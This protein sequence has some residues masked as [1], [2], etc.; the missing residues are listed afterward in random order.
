MCE[1]KRWTKWEASNALK[2]QCGWRIGYSRRIT[3]AEAGEVDKAKLYVGRHSNF[4][5][6]P[7]RSQETHFWVKTPLVLQEKCSGPQAG[8]KA[9]K[10]ALY[11]FYRLLQD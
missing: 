3:P 10:L 1:V 4:V 8:S 9:F 5:P 6:N 7:R 11:S 2:G